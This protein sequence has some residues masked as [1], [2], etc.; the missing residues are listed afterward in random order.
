MNL[1][2]NDDE[3]VESLSK[4]LSETNESKEELI[5]PPKEEKEHQ[6]N[7]PL[8]HKLPKLGSPGIRKKNEFKP[9]RSKR[10]EEEIK[11]LKDTKEFVSIQEIDPNIS[12]DQKQNK[13]FNS[14]TETNE[15]YEKTQKNADKSLKK[16]PTNIDEVQKFNNINNFECMKLFTKYQPNFNYNVVIML[17]NKEYYYRMK[18][19]S[20][21]KRKR[22]R[23]PKRIMKSMKSQ[24]STIKLSLTSG[25]KKSNFSKK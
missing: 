4:I 3:K 12:H 10:S 9:H 25:R 22:R 17:L 24:K 20:G 21:S 2:F 6:N 18:Q 23:T 13:E 14:G 16:I 1:D 7:S 15:T 19:K 5:M 11:D 8:L